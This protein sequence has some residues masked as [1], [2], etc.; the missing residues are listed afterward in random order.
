MSAMQRKG[1]V[2]TTFSD[3]DWTRVKY[4]IL[5]TWSSLALFQGCKP[6]GLQKYQKNFFSTEEIAFGE[7]TVEILTRGEKI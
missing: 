3:K 6:F 7:S 2:L 1:A 5:G 4:H